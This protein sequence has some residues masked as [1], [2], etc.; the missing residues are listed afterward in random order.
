MSSDQCSRMALKCAK[1]FGSKLLT[2][3]EG[4]LECLQQVGARRGGEL[5][6]LIFAQILMNFL[7]N[8]ADN[9]ENGEIF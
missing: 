6:S 8:F 2:Y 7:R 4:G 5:F 9:L 1:P 3:K